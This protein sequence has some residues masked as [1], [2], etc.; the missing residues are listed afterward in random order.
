[1][2]V[3]LFLSQK[4]AFFACASLF[5]CTPNINAASQ[6]NRSSWSSPSSWFSSSTKTTVTPATPPTATS[7][8][9]TSI[10]TDPSQLALLQTLAEN[11]FLKAQLKTQ[12][13]QL[14]A[15][16][17]RGTWSGSFFYMAAGL[18]CVAAAAKLYQGMVI[19]KREQKNR[20]IESENLLAQGAYILERQQER[21]SS[22]ISFAQNYREQ[23][24]NAHPNTR[25]KLLSGDTDTVLAAESEI[26]KAT[27]EA[28]NRLR[29]RPPF[30]PK[31]LLQPNA[32]ET[33]ISTSLD[34]MTQG[35]ATGLSAGGSIIKAT[36]RELWRGGLWLTTPL[37]TPA[38]LT[39]P[40]A[41]H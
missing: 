37:Q 25:N 24:L 26:I 2:K 5:A 16:N 7:T 38:A 28:I 34:L 39:P 1:M 6:P 30:V 33:M 23:Y 14:N 35:V 17:Q 40:A 32:V 29:K 27:D 22:E 9:P 20:S 3:R 36:A 12:A 18:L 11:A 15:S 41:V 10:T 21:S 13:E 31:P 4:T 8:A 19:Y